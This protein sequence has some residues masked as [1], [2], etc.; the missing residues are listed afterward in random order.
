MPIYLKKDK[1]EKQLKNYMFMDQF[2]K[3]EGYNFDG[4]FDFKKFL[5]SYINMGFQGSNFGKAVKIFEN[6][7]EEKKKGLKFWMS[8][9]GNMIRDRKS[10]V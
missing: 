5:D 4:D 2:P 1:V 8:F 6:I 3:I 7:L 9:T 10:V